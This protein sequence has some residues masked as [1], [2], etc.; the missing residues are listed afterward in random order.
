MIAAATGRACRSEH[1]GDHRQAVEQ[2]TKA[3]A[4]HDDLELPMEAETLP[5]FG[6]FLRRQGR[7]ADARTPLAEALHIAEQNQA[8]L[9]A[10]Q[11]HAEPLVA[12]GALAGILIRA[13]QA[14]RSYPA[15]ESAQTSAS[16]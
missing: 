7:G 2:F 6:A 13:G 10:G 5:A 14:A 12:G 15:E 9:I 8:G 3:L 4:L 11:A 16:S 1:E